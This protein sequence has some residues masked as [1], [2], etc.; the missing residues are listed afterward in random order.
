[1]YIGNHAD[2]HHD[3]QFWLSDNALW[4][5]EISL[6]KEECEKALA[7]ETPLR[8]ALR[9]L[10]WAIDEHEHALARHE[11]QIAG[12]EHAVSDFERTGRG[13][14]VEMLYLA[15]AHKKE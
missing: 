14:T 5:D 12:H 7:D 8:G 3:H 1:M 15:K 10:A 11:D 13:D 9:R 4:R 6:W 2:M